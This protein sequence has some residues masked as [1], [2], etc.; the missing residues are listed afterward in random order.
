VRDVSKDLDGRKT[1]RPR[2]KTGS[3]I[4]FP[5]I[6]GNSP[7]GVLNLSDKRS[8]SPFT[9]TD[10]DRVRTI[11]DHTLLAIERAY[12]LE[13]FKIVSSQASTDDM[14]GLAN[15]KRLMEVLST[16]LARCQRH[17]R[18]LSVVMADVD[19]FKEYNDLNGHLA[20]DEA[21]KVIAAVLK[22]SVRNI[23]LAC[24][25]GGEEFCL[26]LPDIKGDEALPV[27]ERIRHEIE[28]TRFPG[29]EGMAS[30]SL[31][32]SMGVA[33]FPGLATT[34]HEIIHSA[35][36]ALYEAKRDGRNRVNRAIGDIPNQLSHLRGNETP[37]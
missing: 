10:L 20:G 9:K 5:L 1:V 27:A 35:D 16:E 19:R 15:K 34:A 21:L 31:T 25:Y 4:S 37:A 22:Q 14:T 36:V 29:E 26:V 7:P 2:Y 24:R 32:L 6:P 12:Y 23:D 28:K 11:S 33:D 17:G 30:G 18:P 8:G 3:F 13:K